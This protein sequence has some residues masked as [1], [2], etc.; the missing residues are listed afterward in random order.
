LNTLKPS[1]GKDEQKRQIE[2]AL[3]DKS[4]EA[5]TSQSSNVEKMDYGSDRITSPTETGFIIFIFSLTCQIS[6]F[7]CD[8]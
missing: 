6:L 4:D 8:L 7:V 2:M 3:D 5:Y 1:Y